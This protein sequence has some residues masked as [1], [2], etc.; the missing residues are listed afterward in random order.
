MLRNYGYEPSAGHWPTLQ[1]D[2]PLNGIVMLRWIK[3]SQP[4][5]YCKMSLIPVW[6]RES[7][8]CDIW[9]LRFPSGCSVMNHKDPVDPGKK[10]IRMNILLKRPPGP[11]DSMYIDGPIRKWW[12]F[13]I[14][15]PDLYF[16]GLEP[17]TGSMLMLSLGRRYK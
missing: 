10:H 13:E 15:R 6:I 8:S 16:H 14:F 12:R 7:F 17:I 11:T 5:S 2:S 1:V 3:G 9:L 4:G